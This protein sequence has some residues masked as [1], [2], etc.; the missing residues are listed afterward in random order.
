ME[1]LQLIFNKTNLREHSKSHFYPIP[2]YFEEVLDDLKNTSL[3]QIKSFKLD[4]VQLT[5]EDAQLLLHLLTLASFLRLPW[6][7]Y[8]DLL[9]ISTPEKDEFLEALNQLS[10]QASP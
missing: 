8:K 10:L 1:S 2:P 6:V 5:K 9:K 3:K 7:P 4:I